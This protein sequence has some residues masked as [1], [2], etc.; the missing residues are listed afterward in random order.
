MEVDLGL[1][2]YKRLHIEGTTLRSRSLEYQADLIDR[3][4]F[5]FVTNNFT[6][7][8]VLSGSNWRY[9]QRS[10]DKTVTD[11][12]ARTL[13]RQATDGNWSNPLLLIAKLYNQGVPLD[14]DTIRASRNGRKQK[15]VSDPYLLG[16]QSVINNID[17]HNSGKIIVEVI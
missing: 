16:A 14:G 7:Y 8:H 10:Q 1:I 5:E 11:P 4:I 15:Q 12:F 3:Y 2:L 17:S 6:P 13:I 9:S